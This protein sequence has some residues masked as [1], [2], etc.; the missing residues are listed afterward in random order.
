MAVYS[1]VDG[2]VFNQVHNIQP[3]VPVGN[4]LAM[5]DEVKIRKRRAPQEG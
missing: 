1:T 3:D 5:M 2:F 4:I